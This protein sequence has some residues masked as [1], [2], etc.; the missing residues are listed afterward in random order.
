MGLHEHRLRVSE[1]GDAAKAN[2]IHNCNGCY[3]PD[4][5]IVFVSTATMVGV[6]CVGGSLPVGNLYRLE[7]DGKTI[8]QLTFDQDQDWYP[9]MLANGRLL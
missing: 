2:P 1:H 7:A 9:R 8:S 6:P 4:G 5:R 3:L